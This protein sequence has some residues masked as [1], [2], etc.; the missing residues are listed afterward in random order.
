MYTGRFFKDKKTDEWVVF[1]NDEGS[2]PQDLKPRDKVDVHIE[3]GDDLQIVEVEIKWSGQTKNGDP[4][5]IGT[6]LKDQQNESSEPKQQAS[7][8][9]ST[10]Q[11]TMDLSRRIETLE[12]KFDYLKDYCDDLKDQIEALKESDSDAGASLADDDIPF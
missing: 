12:N 5:A 3:K 10:N 4:G 1:I 7:A 9:T 11:N 6:I 2:N 8:S